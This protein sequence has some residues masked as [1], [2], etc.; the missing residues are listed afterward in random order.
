MRNVNTFFIKLN[1]RKSIINCL[2]R[3]F[4]HG[5]PPFL[6]AQLGGTFNFFNLL[7]PSEITLS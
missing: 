5:V 4:L 2:L 3:S 1:H 7:N 6:L